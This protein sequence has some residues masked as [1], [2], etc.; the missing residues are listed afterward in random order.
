MPG[1][2]KQGPKPTPSSPAAP[3][4]YWTPQGMQLLSEPAAEYHPAPRRYG[5]AL[6]LKCQNRS[7]LIALLRRGLPVS[8]F[9]R[10]QAEIGISAQ[11]LA[12]VAHIAPRTLSRRKRAGRLD[13]DESERLLR[14]GALF[15]QALA[16]L[17]DKA[18]A[19]SWFQTPLRALAGQSPLEYADTEPGAREVEDL[20]GRLEH[21]VFS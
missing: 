3:S 14:I 17:G 19:Q 7:E 9:E 4:L 18:A 13:T 12:H 1:K 15:D 2:P 20:L 5:A 10:L 21:G 16:A 11:T 6:G 8:A